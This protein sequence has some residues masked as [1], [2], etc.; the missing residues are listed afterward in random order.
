[1]PGLSLQ[2]CQQRLRLLEIGRVKA[3]GAP[4]IDGRQQAQ[5]RRLVD[6]PALPAHA[7]SRTM[8]WHTS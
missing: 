4:A 6:M 7:V 5:L 8:A 1:M 2:L 3:L